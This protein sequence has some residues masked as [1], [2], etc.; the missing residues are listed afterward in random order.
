L[1]GSAVSALTTLPRARAGTVGAPPVRLEARDWRTLDAAAIARWDDLARAT[2]EPNP[3]YES[4][5]L[6]P[7]LR[8][9]D[10][11]GEVELLCLE[12]DG[13]LVGLLPLRHERRYYGHALP[14]WGNWLHA[15]I[16]LG[17]PLVAHGFEAAF[18]RQALS[19]CDGNTGT[20]LFLHLSKVPG[21]GPLA[22]ALVRVLDESRRPAATVMREERA[23]L[24]SDLSAEAY[25]EQSLVGK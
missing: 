3:F 8:L 19:W 24:R 6:L 10:P 14:H 2:A 16:F 20:A 7:S 4:W 18:W 1:A 13:R 15:N 17:S 12:S 22:Q 11:D 25:L 5:H 9:F 23:M 21:E